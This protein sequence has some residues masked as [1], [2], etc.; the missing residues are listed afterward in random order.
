MND[1]DN[2]DEM[3]TSNLVVTSDARARRAYWRHPNVQVLV[4]VACGA[5]LGWLEPQLGM[6]VRPLAD[7][8]IGLIKLVIGPIVFLITTTGIAQV[9]DMRKVGRIGLKALVYFEVLTTLALIVGFI[10]GN[11]VRPGAG[12]APP[13]APLSGELIKYTSGQALP[14]FSSFFFKLI[15][16]NVLNPFVQGDL[17]QILM[18]ALLFGAALVL[19]GE[20]AKPLVDTLDRLTAVVFKAT[21]IVMLFAPLGVFG[22]IGFTVGKFGVGTLL[23]LAKLV[24]TAYFGMALFVVVILALVCRLAGLRLFSIL[25][26]IRSEILIALATSSSEAVLPQLAVKLEE[27]GVSRAVVGLVLPTSYSFN[28]T[29]VALTLPISVLFI[30]QVYG[31]HLTWVQQGSI[32]GLMLLTSKGAAGVTGAAFVTLAATVAATNLLPLQGLILLLAVD[33]FMSEARAVVN[34][35]GNVIATIVIGK[36]E[37]EFDQAKADGVLATAS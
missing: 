2:G 22:A 12:V 34:I 3:T 26:Y 9:G 16:D 37:G 6:G 5:L 29:G 23:A 25:R 31:L 21:S 30:E 33:R 10:V 32:F 36:W 7:A 27:V 17:L 13:A 35:V 8:F 14:S 1:K 15:P 20:K 18:I 19:A 4:A 11:I 24:L 28:L